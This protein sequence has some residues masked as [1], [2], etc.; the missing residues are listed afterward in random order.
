MM[1][2]TCLVPYW[3]DVEF[4]PN[5]AVCMPNFRTSSIG[6]SVFILVTAILTPNLIML[7][8]YVRI[9]VT[10]YKSKRKV[11]NFNVNANAEQQAGNHLP[12]PGMAAHGAPLP[13]RSAART[14]NWVSAF[15]QVLEK[16]RAHRQKEEIKLTRTLSAVFLVYNICWMPMVTTSMLQV[17]GKNLARWSLLIS[18]VLM[19][20][21][22]AVN[23]YIYGIGNRQYRDAIQQTFKYRGKKNEQAFV[24]V[25]EP[26]GQM[27]KWWNLI[28]RLQIKRTESDS[29]V[30]PDKTTGDQKLEMTLANALR[31]IARR[32]VQ[33]VTASPMAGANNARSQR[34]EEG[35]GPS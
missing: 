10:V 9:F 3:S 21:S 25:T 17:Y 33:F 5:S 29:D 13:F 30:T 22:S 15:T 18:T 6:F 16:R 32:N 20:F 11:D 24:K 23:P 14:E 31:I 26:K 2:T 4:L 12:L 1:S 8:S 19:F 27:G 7:V 28:E 34:S 35:E